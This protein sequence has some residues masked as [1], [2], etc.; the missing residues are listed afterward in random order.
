MAYA[1]PYD[2]V[3]KLCEELGVDFQALY[4]LLA[5]SGKNKAALV[6]A[7]RLLAEG[8]ATLTLPS[9]PSGTNGKAAQ[10]NGSP[11]REAQHG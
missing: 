9:S 6:K 3:P 7:L 1:N 2:Q 5:N 11:I 10:V 8:G 4:N